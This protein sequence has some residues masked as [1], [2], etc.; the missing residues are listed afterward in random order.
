MALSEA[1]SPTHFLTGVTSEL[2]L[3]ALVIDSLR[4]TCAQRLRVSKPFL[5]GPAAAYLIFLP[6][7][8]AYLCVV[9]AR[10]DTKI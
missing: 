3:S 10:I 9:A 5:V 4:P 7:F 8:C 1:R 6:L 2:T